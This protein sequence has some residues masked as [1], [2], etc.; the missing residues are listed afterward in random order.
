MCVC[1]C[2]RVKI[3]IRFVFEL[4]Y[5]EIILKSRITQ[6]KKILM[7]KQFKKEEF[8]YISINKIIYL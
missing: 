4:P 3:I 6:L 5:L 1:V 7:A 8:E 2:V